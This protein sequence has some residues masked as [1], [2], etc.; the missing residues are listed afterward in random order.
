[1]HGTRR[2]R[3][4][5]GGNDLE[6]RKA[7]RKSHEQRSDDTARTRRTEMTAVVLTQCSKEHKGR[8]KHGNNNNNVYCTACDDGNSA[9]AGAGAG[10]GPDAS[11][12]ITTAL[13]EAEWNGLWNSFW[14]DASARAKQEELAPPGHHQPPLPKPTTATKLSPTP[15]PAAGLVAMA[16]GEGDACGVR[17]CR[18][19]ARGA[20][21]TAA[22]AATVFT[23]AQLIVGFHPDQATEPSIDLAL[24]LEIPF[25]ICPCCTFDPCAVHRA[26]YLRARAL[27]LC[28]VV[29][30]PALTFLAYS[31]FKHTFRHKACRLL[32]TNTPFV[33]LLVTPF[34]LMVARIRIIQASFRP[35]SRKD[36]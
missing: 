25:V 15:L 35:F 8:R 18:Q 29:L 6:R 36:G 30:V 26:R 2:N 12:G 5:V 11:A 27:T 16:D 23:T 10:A 17:V 22:E 9:G 4:N 14:T 1:M 34:V 20:A 13:T 19:L 24:M 3:A 7:I 32:L 21:T 28:T 31:T 33:M